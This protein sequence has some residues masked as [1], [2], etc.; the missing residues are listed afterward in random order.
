VPEV[1]LSGAEYAIFTV[2]LGSKTEVMTGRAGCTVN[3][4]VL[5]TPLAVPL[6]VT[7]VG[8]VTGEV[9]MGNVALTSPVAIVTLAGTFAAA[10]LLLVSVTG[11]G[12]TA[13]PSRVTVPVAD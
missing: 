2:P 11:V 1:A 9:A 7:C 13:G 8:T 6:I 12:D 4:P 10:V 5:V 3:E